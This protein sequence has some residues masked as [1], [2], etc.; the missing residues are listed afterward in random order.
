MHDANLISWP[1]HMADVPCKHDQGSVGLGAILNLQPFEVLYYDN[2]ENVKLDRSSYQE[3]Y[4]CL[5]TGSKATGIRSSQ[6]DDGAALQGRGSGI[7]RFAGQLIG[8]RRSVHES[9]PAA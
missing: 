1:V 6:R 5:E 8:E 7:R 2:I 4:Q 9:W 3:C